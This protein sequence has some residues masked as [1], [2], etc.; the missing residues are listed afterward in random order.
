MFTEVPPLIPHNSNKYPLKHHANVP[1]VILKQLQWGK[2]ALEMI[3]SLSLQLKNVV[4][5]Q[6]TEHMYVF[7]PPPQIHIS[8]RKYIFW[9]NKC[10]TSDLDKV[11]EMTLPVPSPCSSHDSLFYMWTWLPKLEHLI[12]FCSWTEIYTIGSPGF[13]IYI[14]ISVSVSVSV[15]LSLPTYLSYWSFWRDF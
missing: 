7:H 8:N 3:S 4:W 15:S 6:N 10:M 5:R 12:F 2:N 13:Q 9:K 14:S 1:V 11:A